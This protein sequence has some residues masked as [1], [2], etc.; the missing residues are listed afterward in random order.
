[1]ADDDGAGVSIQKPASRGGGRPA[2]KPTPDQRAKVRELRSMSP[3]KTI[4][5]VA[6]AIGLSR[7]TLKK[8]FAEELDA[9]PAS[10]PAEQQLDLSGQHRVAPPPAESREPGRPEF[11]PTHRQR[12]DVKLCKADNWSDDRI[13]R[14]LGISRSTLLRHF[15]HELE[16]GV[17]ILRV[18]VLR[19]LKTAAGKGNRAAAE[20]LLGLPGMISGMEVLPTPSEEEP[21]PQANVEATGVGLGKKER[22]RRDAQTAHLGTP[23]ER[24]VN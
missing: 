15:G 4:E 2:Y 22:A 5:E 23:W 6:S 7:N 10:A 20:T 17:D 14:F 8:Y 16:L 18:Q 3:A 21:A 19:D 13:A 12:E 11:E 9:V 1:M 24:L